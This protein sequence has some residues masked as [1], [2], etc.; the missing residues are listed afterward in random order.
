MNFLSF[1]GRGGSGVTQQSLLRH[2]TVGLEGREKK[3]VLEE[4]RLYDSPFIM[5]FNVLHFLHFQQPLLLRSS[6]S[7]LL[8]LG[9]RRL[10]SDTSRLSFME[11]LISIYSTL[12]CRIK[13]CLLANMLTQGFEKQT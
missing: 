1:S 4:V 2:I 3:T 10:G 6:V 12:G 7:L 13:Q 11:Q 5:P 8:I 9:E